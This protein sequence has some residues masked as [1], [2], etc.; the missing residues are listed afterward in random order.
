MSFYFVKLNRVHFIKKAVSVV[1]SQMVLQLSHYI[2]SRQTPKSLLFKAVSILPAILQVQK[3]IT[4]T[5]VLEP[6]W[7]YTK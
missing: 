6:N 5:Q 4:H 3:F 7:C 2:T 1:K